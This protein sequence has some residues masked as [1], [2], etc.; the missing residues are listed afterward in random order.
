MAFRGSVSRR[1]SGLK[2][3]SDLCTWN[4]IWSR[5]R[6]M[7]VAP[8]LPPLPPP[9][10]QIM[11]TE[12]RCWCCSPH[13]LPTRVIWS[14][15]LAGLTILTW[16][17]CYQTHLRNYVKYLSIALHARWVGGQA[18]EDARGGLTC[19]THSPRQARLLVWEWPHVSSWRGVRHAVRTVQCR[20]YAGPSTGIMEGL[21]S[22]AV[23]AVY[24]Y[25]ARQL[26]TYRGSSHADGAERSGAGRSPPRSVFE[27]SVLNE[28]VSASSPAAWT[29]K[30]AGLSFCSSNRCSAEPS[31]LQHIR[32][33]RHM[34]SRAGCGPAAWVDRRPAASGQ[35]PAPALVSCNLGRRPAL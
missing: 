24:T 33:S 11:T 21:V 32:D 27:V 35:R 29:K 5:S 4:N 9:N 13:Y 8:P 34:T 6:L 23:H 15:T 31:A 26:D 3:L 2:A 16:Q 12:S 20:P 22:F 25:L 10:R 7:I 18:R 28:N 19:P 1:L 14:E 17:T 30:F